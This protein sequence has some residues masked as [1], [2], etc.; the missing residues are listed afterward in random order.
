MARSTS[1]IRTMVKKR[2]RIYGLDE[3]ILEFWKLTNTSVQYT[4]DIGVLRIADDLSVHVKSS[5]P[6]D[7]LCP[8]HSLTAANRLGILFAPFDIPTIY[9]MLGVKKL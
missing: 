8:A 4:I 2:D 7:P 6:A 5:W 1:S 9:R 3:H